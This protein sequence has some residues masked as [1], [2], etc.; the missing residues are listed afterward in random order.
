[1]VLSSVR[2]FRLANLD[3]IITLAD[4]SNCSVKESEGAEGCSN[5]EAQWVKLWELSE[6]QVGEER[7]P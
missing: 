2:A 5:D 4:L 3:C 1:M 6:R 7:F